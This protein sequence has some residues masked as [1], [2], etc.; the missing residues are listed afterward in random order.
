[1][2]DEGTL[3]PPP[4]NAVLLLRVAEEE[5]TTVTGHGTKD[6]RVATSEEPPP[7]K[8]RFEK[9]AS[10][11]GSNGVVVP[12]AVDQFADAP[13]TNNAVVG[14][15]EE[16]CAM[17]V[18]ATATST[19][20]EAVPPGE[21][22]ETSA[23]VP[24]V[25]SEPAV[26]SREE[27]VK[28]KEVGK[29][30]ENV[31][32]LVSV[33]TEVATTED[34]VVK[35]ELAVKELTAIKGE[36]AVKEDV[37]MEREVAIKRDVAEVL[38]AY[39]KITAAPTE[40][41]EDDDD[42]LFGGGDEDEPTPAIKAEESNAAEPS[43]TEF[44]EPALPEVA[45]STVQPKREPQAPAV[46]TPS[47]T[48]E[49]AIPRKAASATKKFET[50]PNLS[51]APSHNRVPGAK[52][53]LPFGVNVPA[54]IVRT[55]LLEVEMNTPGSK[56]MEVL[57][58][59]PINLINDAL[60]E[61]DDA[62]EIKGATAI[63]NH[64]AYLYGVV[65]RYVSV[66]ER[67]MSGEGT[68]ILP[69]GED[70]LTATVQIRLD[71]LVATGFCSTQEMN[72]KVK[73]KIRMLS[74]K[75][76]LFALDEL[77]SVERSSIRNFGSYF[78]G[79]LNRYMRGDASSKIRP[80]QA[81]GGSGQ[82]THQHQQQFD[83][84]R[85]RDRLHPRD[86]NNSHISSSSSSFR[87]RSRDQFDDRRG[88][89]DFVAYRN[90]NH[91]SN[92]NPMYDNRS[93]QQ[94]W[95]NQPPPQQQQPM[96]GGAYGHMGNG[97]PLQQSAMPMHTMQ[98][99]VPMNQQ[100]GLP[101]NQQQTLSGMQ[102]PNLSYPPQQQPYLHQ[103]QQQPPYM[104]QQ[105]PFVQQTGYPPIS[106]QGMPS[107]N[108]NMF[109]QQQQPQN[110]MMGLQQQ[111]F[112]GNQPPQQQY[113]PPMMNQLSPFVQDPM[114]NTPLGGWQRQQEAAQIPV[115]ILGLAD[116]AASAIQ[117][118]G[119]NKLNPMG[120]GYAA[121][122]QHLAGP[123]QQQQGYPLY[124][125]GNPMGQG[126]PP[127]MGMQQQQYPPQQQQFPPQQQLVGPGAFNRNN[128]NLDQQQQET[129]R[130]RRTTSSLVELPITVQYAVQ[131]RQ[132]VTARCAAEAKI[133]AL[134][135][136]GFALGCRSCLTPTVFP[137]IPNRISLQLAPLM[138]SQMKAYWV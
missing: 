116:K 114:M 23:V 66:H 113:V 69:M 110:N 39:N 10:G 126:Q 84:S 82:Q 70:G 1:M 45:P 138:A 31:K 94:P 19:M 97:P 123:P 96:G 4:A 115:D 51:H 92:M 83:R 71:Q 125:G 130:R 46:T 100:Q 8:V 87:D 35:Q 59:L 25:T 64:G 77:S 22:N 111:Q 73:S 42:D 50:S 90:D 65:K 86:S 56:L 47:K 48:D 136:C 124:G 108:S 13:D 120:Q 20:V 12:V 132:C 127:I 117:A 52:Y 57:K 81:S 131:V 135:P 137:V 128:N 37:A 133:R 112:V 67:A 43:T 5:T 63:R 44:K 16:E 27:V 62:V 30:E 76:A 101:M 107:S 61:Y 38:E 98:Q 15:E 2:T 104:Q 14:E 121:P 118:L 75:D 129:T 11:D 80:P 55:K 68:G 89:K 103:Q 106:Q 18:E 34:E 9:S 74:E 109:Q 32:A 26:A 6:S 93:Q 54:S 7:K 105:Q 53:G 29:G 21:G 85:D 88:S 60:T 36:E 78:M 17:S 102:Q 41:E 49:M 99:G 58:S 134:V 95:Q 24:V 33:K 91:G 79:I 122:Q 119:A 40:E 28:G 72:D 3:P